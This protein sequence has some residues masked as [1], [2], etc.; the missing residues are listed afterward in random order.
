MARASQA[1]ESSEEE[2]DDSSPEEESDDQEEE[3]IED[4]A[5]GEGEDEEDEDDDLCPVCDGKCTCAITVDV[6]VSARTTPMSFPRQ[7]KTITEQPVVRPT[8]RKPLK[9][10]LVRAP[11]TFLDRKRRMS[12]CSNS[13]SSL[14]SVPDSESEAESSSPEKAV[15][16]FNDYMK[17][18]RPFGR[19]VLLD[20]S[21]S[22]DSLSSDDSDDQDIPL[23][24]AVQERK[25]AA[26]ALKPT[27]GQGVGK[28]PSRNTTTPKKAGKT[29]N[30]ETT[31]STTG[32]KRR[33]TNT[34]IA[35][36]NTNFS[37]DDNIDDSDGE[38]SDS[39]LSSLPPIDPDE[40]EG[41]Y[42]EERAIIE[43]EKAAEAARLEREVML[44]LGLSDEEDH[45]LNDAEE[46]V[47]EV[48]TGVDGPFG[49]EEEDDDDD[50]HDHDHDDEIYDFDLGSPLI[51]NNFDTR[52][53]KTEDA[54]YDS[55]QFILDFIDEASGGRRGSNG[56][57]YL[58]W[59]SDNED[60]EMLDAGE[61]DD[62]DEDMS[63]DDDADIGWNVFLEE[64][65]DDDDQKDEIDM[66][67]AQV[68]DA[69]EGETTDE[70]DFKG[71]KTATPGPVIMHSSS[72]VPKTAQKQPVLGMWSAAKESQGSV[73]II[74]GITTVRP[75]DDGS[76]T[77]PTPPFT[78]L[79][80]ILDVGA[81]ATLPTGPGGPPASKDLSRWDRIPIGTFRRAQTRRKDLT[82]REEHARE[83]YV[84][85]SR[86]NEMMASKDANASGKKKKGS[87]SVH[88]TPA[89]VHGAIGMAVL[90][91]PEAVRRKNK[92]RMKKL[93]Q[94][95]KRRELEVMDMDMNMTGASA[96]GGLGMGPTLSPLFG[97]VM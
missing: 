35:S 67:W 85:A 30:T 33:N 89:K 47:L 96:D 15:K 34:S 95:K 87:R 2:D 36:G 44:G 97:A 19:L 41:E 21:S 88:G 68:D 6:E 90:E 84:L 28:A 63:S 17:Q 1:F 60:D 56:Q 74:D 13:S 31:P 9:L 86:R 23:S 91:D 4:E 77:L 3:A 76:S 75:S 26:K 83:W 32:K 58:G 92:K 52:P 51:P 46:D 53:V 49:E 65:G 82:A 57:T 16:E 70:E 39:S 73:G 14:S 25:K 38:S 27:T 42:E 20:D 45:F 29:P 64:D 78:T 55:D 81:L 12:T 94:K 5:E 11:Q 93:A 61:D 54:D 40:N 66:L 80:D 8:V 59:L 62:E 48:E 10:V 24:K 43:E 69:A 72:T 18:N 22:D 50:D 37:F 7:P 79:D 71:K